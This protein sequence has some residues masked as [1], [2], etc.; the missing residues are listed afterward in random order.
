MLELARQPERHAAYVGHW[1]KNLREDPRELYRAAKDAQGISDYVLE[2]GP[3]AATPATAAPA[4][5]GQLRPFNRSGCSP[6]RQING[7]TARQFRSP[8]LA[9]C[10]RNA[11]PRLAC[12]SSNGLR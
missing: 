3:G 7:M 4:G 11:T 9:I 2:F 6:G 5:A 1:I 10:T 12:I 8:R